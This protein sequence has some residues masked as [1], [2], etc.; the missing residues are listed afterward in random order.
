MDTIA[1]LDGKRIIL[2]VTGSIASYKSLDLVSKLTQSGVAVDVIMT[3]AAQRFVAPLSFQALSGRPVY[4]DL[5]RSDA[6]GGLAD[7][8]RARGIGGGS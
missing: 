6:D 4:T 7:T 8:H 1:L 3:E 5:W 2:G